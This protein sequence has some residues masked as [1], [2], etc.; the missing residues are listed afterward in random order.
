[1]FKVFVPLP[2]ISSYGSLCLLGKAVINPGCCDKMFYHK[3]S[4]RG[5]KEWGGSEGSDLAEGSSSLKN[6]S[7]VKLLSGCSPRSSDNYSLI[8]HIGQLLFVVLWL[9]REYVSELFMCSLVRGYIQ[10]EWRTTGISNRIPLEGEYLERRKSPS[11][12][13]QER[14]F[15]LY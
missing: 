6:H 8:I 11:I 15:M 4:H 3:S 10:S 7:T 1:M 2:S 12:F 13:F 5:E 9:L 14:W